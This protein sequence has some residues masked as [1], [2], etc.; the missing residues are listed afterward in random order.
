MNNKVSTNKD[1]FDLPFFKSDEKF[2]SVLSQMQEN[3]GRNCSLLENEEMKEK[4][5][6][7]DLDT[8]HWTP[9]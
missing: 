8:T 3:L 7:V 2:D 1:F 4:D 6:I 9:E 5:K